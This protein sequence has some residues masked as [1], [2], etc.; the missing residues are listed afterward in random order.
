MKRSPRKV[1][2]MPDGF[3][4]APYPPSDDAETR[5]ISL[6]ESALDK[7]V[8]ADL[9]K[10]D[11]HPNSDGYLEIVD[12]EGRPTGKLEVQ[13]RTIPGGHRKY[14]CPTSLMAYSARTTLPFFLICT[15]LENEI[16]YWVHLTP[17]LAR[18]KESQKSVMIPL[19]AT[20]DQTC[21]YLDE[22]KRITVEWQQRISDF[23]RLKELEETGLLHDSLAGIEARFVPPLQRFVDRLNHLVGDTFALLFKRIFPNTWKVGI[24]VERVDDR[25][26]RYV[27]YRIAIGEHGSLI[28]RSRGSVFGILRDPSQGFLAHSGQNELTRDPEESANRFVLERIRGLIRTGGLMI[29]NAFVCR[30]YLAEFI[31]R[32]DCALRL[33]ARNDYAP[34]EIRHAVERAMRSG[35][36]NCLI[37]TPQRKGGEFDI[38]S[39]LRS[40]TIAATP[41]GPDDPMTRSPS[42]TSV[43]LPMSVRKA[44]GALHYLQERSRRVPR[45]VYAPRDAA[46]NGWIWGGYTRGTVR[47]NAAVVFRDLKARYVEFLKA[48]PFLLLDTKFFSEEF[49]NRL[50][51]SV[52]DIA[53][54]R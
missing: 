14:Q 51:G 8:K 17:Q 29:G 33:E 42:G 1:H 16:V 30:E 15:D 27:L 2:A 40:T 47:R 37:K 19:S 50:L 39:V 41:E 35:H 21:A 13:V 38:L 4:P 45:A 23:P 44:L 49:A 24:A 48:N 32:N 11:K 36:F 9:R 53:R 43:L 26:I 5:S 18:G 31:H 28:R 10:R 20:I 3:V 22:W 7:R 12:N 54:S 6:L 34:E 52:D 25:V 46:P